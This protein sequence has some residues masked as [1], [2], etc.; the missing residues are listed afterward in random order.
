VAYFLRKALISIGGA[1]VGQRAALTFEN[2]L[3]TN[4]Y[5]AVTV[6]L[7][8]VLVAVLVKVDLSAVALKLSKAVRK[9]D[10]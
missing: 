9:T 8:I 6:L 3:P 5:I 4:E 2:L 10:C 1:Y 7:S